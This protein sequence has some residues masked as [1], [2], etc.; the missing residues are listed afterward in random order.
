MVEEVKDKYDDRGTFRYV[1]R[2]RLRVQHP[3]HLAMK[4]IEG[5]TLGRITLRELV[6]DL[7]IERR[8]EVPWL[9]GSPVLATLSAFRARSEAES[10]G[11]AFVR[12]LLWTLDRSRLP[13]DD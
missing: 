7:E 1:P 3:A 12:A 9:P 11:Q 6:L 8:R 4:E 5:R 13:C 2:F 10:A